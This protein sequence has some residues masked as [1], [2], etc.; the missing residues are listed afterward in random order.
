[1]IVLFLIQQMVRIG[2]S[3]EKYRDAKLQQFRSQLP[4]ENSHVS[5]PYLIKGFTIEF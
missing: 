2:Q 3:L 5:L 1:M 4:S